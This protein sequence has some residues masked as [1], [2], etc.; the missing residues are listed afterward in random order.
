MR[1]AFSILLVVACGS[2]LVAEAATPN[3]VYIMVDDMGPADAGFMGS[4]A[5]STPNLDRLA[6]QSLHFT[7]AYS[8]CTVCAPSRSVLL[9]GKHMGR[10]SVRLNTGGV[11]LLDEDVTIAE[12]LKQAGYR[13]GGF[14][15]WGL[16]DIGTSGAA[17]RQGFDV[18]YGYYHQIHA[19]DHYPNFL[20]RNGEK[21]S[22]TNSEPNT[23]R[24]Y[25]PELIFAEMKE[26]IRASVAAD[27]PF[28]CYAPWTPPH[29]GYEFPRSDPAWKLYKDNAWPGNQRGHAAM[30]TLID[31]YVGETLQLL[32]ELGV[33]D[34][35]V[36]VFH[37][38]NGA[39]LAPRSCPDINS[40]GPFR[41]HKRSPYEGGVRAPT[42]VYWKGQ[43]APG[44]NSTHII[45][46]QDAMPTLAELAGATQHLP[47]DITGLSYAPVLFGRD[48]PETHD[49]HYWEWAAWDW[50]R[51]TEVPG[52][53]MQ[54]L[55]Q[56]NWKIARVRNDQPWEL[57]NLATDVGETND[58]AN[59]HPDKVR[60]LA[61]LVAKA[62]VPMR[63][64]QEPAHPEG[65]A[66]N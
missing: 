3:F 29:G 1:N 50:G 51:H 25:A 47:P 41:G 53:L 56:Q 62:R 23:A 12:V 61:T 33:L 55:R 45:S 58:L 19:H 36:V 14:G 39:S 37:S 57:Y 18:F 35:T 8:G 31:R 27:E 4:Q 38:D 65:Q 52:G 66:F 15:K 10:T 49:F 42:L 21:E 5:I 46:A 32:S 6:A 48:A 17:E 22:I 63:P 9:T 40:S 24:G 43:I 54:A 34:N 13:T 64:Q 44:K 11:P 60:E 20:V 26:F 7:E 2:A 16:G 28:F 59:E 30:V